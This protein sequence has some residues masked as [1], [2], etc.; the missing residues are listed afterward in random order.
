MSDSSA[1][2][3]FSATP[4]SVSINEPIIL[5][6]TLVD[7]TKNLPIV[8]QNVFL[9]VNGSAGV[10]ST[11]TDANGNFSMRL[12]EAVGNNYS[13]FVEYFGEG[14]M[15]NPTCYPCVSKTIIVAFKGPSPNMG[16]DKGFIPGYDPSRTLIVGGVNLTEAP[17]YTFLDAS[18]KYWFLDGYQG[19]Q[20]N[21]HPQKLV[22]STQY[23]KEW[24]ISD[25]LKIVPPDQ[26]RSTMLTAYQA[27]SHVLD[28]TRGDQ[29]IIHGE[30][31]N[32]YFVGRR[33]KSSVSNETK[34]PFTMDINV[35]FAC[36]GPAYSVQEWTTHAPRPWAYDEPGVVFYIYSYGDALAWPRYRYTVGETYSGDISIG[37]ATTQ[38]EVVWNGTIG[39]GQYL[40]FVMD[41]QYG[42]P[43][44]VYKSGANAISGTR[45]PA[46]PHIVP[47]WNEMYWVG[48]SLGSLEIRWRDRYNIGQIDS[49]P[50]VAP[51]VSYTLPPQQVAP[52]PAGAIRYPAICCTDRQIIGDKMRLFVTDSSGIVYSM[53]NENGSWLGW[54]RIGGT[55]SSTPSCTSNGRGYINISGRGTDGK[56][57]WRMSSDHGM[58]WDAWHN[59]GGILYSGTAPSC[60]NWGSGRVDW[61]VTGTTTNCYHKASSNIGTWENLG[62]LCTSS[63]ASVAWDNNRIDIFV[64]GTDAQLWQKTW[65]GS[66]WVPTGTWHPLGGKI[67]ANT[68]PAVTSSSYNNLD[69]F[70]IGTDSALYQKSWIDGRG[71]TGWSSLGGICTSSPTACYYGDGLVVAVMGSDNNIWFRATEN[72]VLK[73]WATIA[74][75]QLEPSYEWIE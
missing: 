18:S 63:P 1:I 36:T 28:P 7:T 13:L 19:P 11:A 69:V 20:F 72:N 15:P 73:P 45:G 43:Y 50:T 33:S 17:Y 49:N 34:V 41:Y 56:L 6:G 51:V 30:F 46:W 31:P 23:L 48:D 26:K 58:T 9:T 59:I 10:I 66:A 75:V 8:N 68:S 22:N 70:V 71:W 16:D 57:Y 62:G 74:N 39:R 32:S 38:E 67:M 52:L 40:D 24:N 5:S 35:D 54:E 14:V 53:L 4:T 55:L 37:N 12:I 3:N 25:V 21:T 27:L 61:F 29:T 47:G 2:I 44:T 60:T 64:R 42:I 65:N